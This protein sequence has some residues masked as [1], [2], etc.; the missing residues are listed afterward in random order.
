[1]TNDSD[2][3]YRSWRKLY[4]TLEEAPDT[5]SSDDM[6]KII[7]ARTRNLS[8]VMKD[9]GDPSVTS[10]NQVKSGTI[11]MGSRSVKISGPVVQF[12]IQLGEFFHLDALQ[13]FT[14]FDS[15]VEQA[16]RLKESSPVS[17][18]DTTTSSE[19]YPYED[20]CH[21]SFWPDLLAYYY[22]ERTC[23]LKALQALIRITQ[24]PEHLY[25]NSGAY[26]L[27]QW[28][29]MSHS[30][31]STV[32]YQYIDT[33]KRTVPSIFPPTLMPQW[34]CQ[35]WEEQEQLL[36]LFSLVLVARPTC[37]PPQLREFLGELIRVNALPESLQSHIA[38]SREESLRQRVHILANLVAA[39][40]LHLPS[41]TRVMDQTDTPEG[42][43]LLQSPEVF[44]DIEECLRNQHSL[45]LLSLA[46]GLTWARLL[47]LLDVLED[48]DRYQALRESLWVPDGEEDQSGDVLANNSEYS[49]GFNQVGK[50]HIRW[51]ALSFQ[52]GLL[53]FLE[54]TLGSSCLTEDNPNALGYRQILKEQLMQLC[55]CLEVNRLPDFER[56]VECTARLFFRQP[57]LCLQFWTEDMHHAGRAS[58]LECAQGRFPYSFRPFMHLITA[59][60]TPECAEHVT[61]YFQQLPTLTQAVL[62]DQQLA[63]SIVSSSLDIT[64]LETVQPLAVL[65][66]H[67]GL[68]LPIHTNG[69]QLSGSG[70]VM[71]VKWQHP[72]V[73]WDY[74]HHLLDFIL[75]VAPDDDLMT[76]LLGAPS[77]LVIQD[78]LWMYRQ[79]FSYFFGQ[80]QNCVPTDAL[81]QSFQEPSRAQDE[82]ID[83]LTRILVQ[84]T[85][86]L[87]TDGTGRI[88]PTDSTNPFMNSSDTS[89]AG[90]LL[91]I[92]QLGLDCLYQLSTGYPLSVLQALER[93]DII[94]SSVAQATRP[95]ENYQRAELIGGETNAWLNTL[96]QLESRRT[97]FDA[98]HSYIRLVSQL[99]F[100]LWPYE[101]TTVTSPASGMASSAKRSLASLDHHLY[102]TVDQ[103][104]SL[105][106]LGVHHQVYLRLPKMTFR[107]VQE[108]ADLTTSLMD[109]YRAFFQY[110]TNCAR[111]H[112]YAQV[113]QQ[114]V[115]YFIVNPTLATWD[116]IYYS[117][118]HAVEQLHQ[119]RCSAH[120]VA[121]ES[122]ETVVLTTL[123]FLRT[124]VLTM[125]LPGLHSH[126]SG[127]LILWRDLNR[128]H[129]RK[130]ILRILYPCI[131]YPDRWDIPEVA[132]AVTNLVFSLTAQH[133]LPLTLADD[134][135]GSEVYLRQLVQYA[136]LPSTARTRLPLMVIQYLWVH[137][138]AHPVHAYALLTGYLPK[139][140]RSVP[141]TE[142]APVSL[143][144][145]LIRWVKEL[146][147]SLRTQ[148]PDLLY[149]A[150]VV[151][152]MVLSP[153]TG[154]PPVYHT[155]QK[156]SAFWS[157]VLQ[158]AL[159]NPVPPLDTRDTATSTP[160]ET[161][162]DDTDPAQTDRALQVYYKQLLVQKY[163]LPLLVSV[164]H[165]E[166]NTGA[167]QSS[168]SALTQLC[169]D[170]VT[171]L[172]TTSRIVAQTREFTKF[173]Y[174]PT[175]QHELNKL[176]TDLEHAL[177]IRLTN[178]ITPLHRQ[179]P[180]LLW[181]PWLG[182][183]HG[184]NLPLVEQT[185]TNVCTDTD[186]V[187]HALKVL[188]RAN[189]Q[190]SLMVVEQER[191]VAWGTLLVS[192]VLWQKVYQSYIGTSTSDTTNTV[193]LACALCKI[194]IERVKELGTVDNQ[195]KALIAC[196]LAK[197]AMTMTSLCLVR[198]ER[199]T[200]SATQG[201]I[202]EC[203]TPLN[204]LT[205][206]TPLLMEHLSFP[207][208]TSDWV[209]HYPA[210]MIFRT[211]LGGVGACLLTRNA[212]QNSDAATTQ[213]MADQVKQLQS[214]ACE[215]L[216]RIGTAYG[217]WL[218]WKIEHQ[219]EESTSLAVSDE[220]S[221]W[222]AN[223][224]FVLTTSAYLFHELFRR[225]NNLYPMS[226]TITLQQHNMYS[227]LA[228]QLTRVTSPTVLQNFL[229]ILC[230]FSNAPSSAEQ[231]VA[232]EI[233]PNLGRCPLW[234][235]LKDWCAE[236]HTRG[237]ST[238]NQPGGS[239]TKTIPN[240]VHP[241]VKLTLSLLTNLTRTLGHHAVV[242]SQVI[243]TLEQL[244]PYLDHV[245]RGLYT[246][247]SGQR[248]QVYQLATI[249]GVV[250]LATAAGSHAKFWT[251]PLLPQT[252]MPILLRYIYWLCRP[253]QLRVEDPWLHEEVTLQQALPT[254]DTAENTLA[255]TPRWD[256][257]Q[258]NPTSLFSLTVIGSDPWHDS[259]R[260]YIGEEI[261]LD[262]TSTSTTGHEAAYLA[263]THT[264]LIQ[265]VLSVIR[266]CLLGLFMFTPTLGQIGELASVHWDSDDRLL[267]AYREFRQRCPWL[268]LSMT[269]SNSH[270]TLG[271]LLDLTSECL[272]LLETPQGSAITTSNIS[273]S[274]RSVMFRPSTLAQSRQTTTIDNPSA[275]LGTSRTGATTSTPVTENHF[276][277]PT[278]R[279]LLVDI[280][281]STYMYILAQTAMLSRVSVFPHQSPGFP[282]DEGYGTATRFFK[283][284]VLPS[285]A[286]DLKDS[287]RRV[288]ITLEPLVSRLAT[289]STTDQVTPLQREKQSMKELQ[290]LCKKLPELLQA[291]AN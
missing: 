40:L 31:P 170:L 163:T 60:F 17:A 120:L 1:M 128:S 259:L 58:L 228:D 289:P 264:Q 171:Q 235:Q 41:P 111:P 25:H 101:D 172:L 182:A 210:F 95:G 116:P 225:E 3:I 241:T 173:T 229:L 18:A 5:V 30:L 20:Y 27:D 85:H 47:H 242:Q 53:D 106:L 92:V 175:L 250:R 96:V 127:L 4:I 15:F 134:V 263:E 252:M 236:S 81:N 217:E 122:L 138:R 33:R 42:R 114:W 80:G 56:L 248:W 146:S 257:N 200:P 187:N 36:E 177:G 51:I 271:T 223:F 206:L 174:D 282:L 192:P 110:G 265:H 21:H 115:Q 155:L 65:P 100:Q 140:G 221:R 71:I 68:M 108:W 291:L 125:Y 93:H 152:Q 67:P 288:Q 255:G 151:F 77:H 69:L 48:V 131:L 166:S 268:E 34:A 157:S 84:A 207:P 239:P 14:I 103:A 273:S 258:G 6:L 112:P 160:G 218:A 245:V 281:R 283:D 269:T 176:Q 209:S 61:N 86:T 290:G 126:S 54:I 254:S 180:P 117:L 232:K 87:R 276:P 193:C 201:R 62:A 141:S 74:F 274:S 261:A 66:N 70:R 9:F 83:Q 161:G 284:N 26:F 185:L 63:L 270:L 89:V 208:E 35:L 145:C 50:R 2:P 222:D 107:S 286:R 79:V 12:V 109:L 246:N 45:P 123:Q 24:D 147:D 102:A 94:P 183:T 178:Y 75:E 195:E 130:D 7:T 168:S 22:I 233:I 256:I 211:Y 59:L 55:S 219:G 46:W 133:R 104:L 191:E 11:P 91:S 135:V 139:V 237:G 197:I 137:M 129:D 238:P 179:L 148:D 154:V 203:D 88:P 149:Y 184:Y 37:S 189:L 97:Q 234:S 38:D 231:M 262:S 73:P 272:T 212:C 220:G 43:T 260:S 253:S 244:A 214:P 224:E 39:Q 277:L 29:Q 23:K 266:N 198:A 121:V 159:T 247:G 230:S 44:M 205:Q 181:Y 16:E 118:S 8:L 278:V 287:V 196:N 249:D 188:R 153:G 162:N 144:R 285:V 194:M 32:L 279:T 215:W 72:F 57:E 216:R 132:L 113:Y 202:P 267:A 76:A 98:T 227:F 78:T 165:G 213:G 52:T 226:S 142:L 167:S 143:G 105:V 136:E 82:L 251:H 164:L 156:D 13:T 19:L 119:V 124:L 204:M 186:A 275:S 190:R 10:T 158:L 199:K 28:S 280:L 90:C 99:V 243:T 49:N 169:S 64:L 240:H 150:L